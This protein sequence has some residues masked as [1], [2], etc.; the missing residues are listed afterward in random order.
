MKIVENSV[1]KLSDNR[2]YLV[3]RVQEIEN[4]KFC[5]IATTSEPIDMKVAVL[6][7]EANKFIIE[8]YKGGDYKYI[9]QILLDA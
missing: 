6:K 5:L 4:V 2:E 3:V 9:L 7:E 1:I 8:Q